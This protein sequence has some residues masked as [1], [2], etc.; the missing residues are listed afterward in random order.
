ME[1]G[2]SSNMMVNLPFKWPR[3]LLL[4]P[5][6]SLSEHLQYLKCGE[7][8]GRCMLEAEAGHMESN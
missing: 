8:L 4:V 6:V 7:L 5:F 2:S 1:M 3:D